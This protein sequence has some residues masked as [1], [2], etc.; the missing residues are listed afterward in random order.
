M[1]FLDRR[2]SPI[3]RS[4]VNE[5]HMAIFSDHPRVDHALKLCG[6]PLSGFGKDFLLIIARDYNTQ[7]WRQEIAHWRMLPSRIEHRFKND[8]L[9]RPH[10]EKFIVFNDIA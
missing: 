2:P 10:T 6:Y 8:G 5:E 1:Q 3:A 7:C 4:V 9:T